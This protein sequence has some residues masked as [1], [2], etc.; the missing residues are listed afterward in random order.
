[1]LRGPL[2]NEKVTLTDHGKVKLNFKTFYSDRTSHLLFTKSEF[3]ERPASK[4]SLPRTQLVRWSGFF[5]PNSPLRKAATLKPK[6]N[7]GFKAKSCDHDT[8]VKRRWCPSKVPEEFILSQS[9][10]KI[11]QD[12]CRKM[13]PL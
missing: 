13:R 5:A 3:I 10:R 12:R 4:V 6:L 2:A 1:M 8:K 11:L 9:A 7:K